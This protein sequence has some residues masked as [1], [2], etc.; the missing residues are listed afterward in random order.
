VCRRWI[1]WYATGIWR[2]LGCPAGSIDG[3]RAAELSKAVAAYEIGPQVDYHERSSRQIELLDGRL[4]LLAGIFFLMT[5]LVSAAV[6]IGLWVAPVW[7]NEH[8][9]WFT[10]FEAGLPALGTAVFGIR[11][12]GDFGGSAIR[13]QATSNAL[14]QIEEELA[15]GA[16][17][18]RAADL[19][20][21]AARIMYSDLDEWRL[22]NQQQDLD[23]V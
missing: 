13:S 18:M 16:T 7:M 19:T 10:L 12:Q 17:L 21:Q 6:L 23:L 20:E 14:R 5:L 2:A 3:R 1:E 11:F 15:K 9:P 22:I 8:D 4:E